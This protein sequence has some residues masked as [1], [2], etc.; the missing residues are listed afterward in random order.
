MK[1]RMLTVFLF[2]SIILLLQALPAAAQV[3]EESFQQ[4]EFNFVPPGARA[5]AMGGSFIALADDATAAITN[6]A[7]L[8]ALIKPEISFELKALDHRV[9]RLAQTQSLSTL[10][11][12]QFGGNPVSPSFISIVYPG[13]NWALGIFRHEYLNF[14]DEYT[15]ERRPIPGTFFEFVPAV[16]S[17][18]ILGDQYGLSF[19]LR[20]A[21]L[22]WGVNVKFVRMKIQ[23]SIQRTF[24]DPVLG[25]YATNEVVLDDTDS[26]LGFSLGFLWHLSPKF[27]IG[28][29][30]Q[31]NPRMQFEDETLTVNNLISKTST[32][33]NVTNP[34]IGIPN[35]IG[36]GFAYR[37]LDALVVTA[38]VLWVQLSRIFDQASVIYQNGPNITPDLFTIDDRLEVHAGL[39]YVL[40][41][42][43]TPLALRTGGFLVPQ[44]R[45]HYQPLGNPNP[46]GEEAIDHGFDILYNGLP[47]DT[48]FGWSVGLGIVLG[49]KIQL[50]VAYSLIKTLHQ[51]SASA[52]IRF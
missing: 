32:V 48:N 39:E 18:D 25:P 22:D 27:Q 17:V 45:I 49:G 41:L 42:G 7:G 43:E 11:P 51:F 13:H 10:E 29:S 16:G 24:S 34:S 44:R 8:L 9:D 1:L 28:G 15:L 19:A 21:S 35:L 30:A 6:P 50:D 47:E 20:T 4:M 36:G 2:A 23:N 38:D 14:E 31:F 3:D 37:P 52:V 5:T 12:T 33:T 40:F 26:G 46:G